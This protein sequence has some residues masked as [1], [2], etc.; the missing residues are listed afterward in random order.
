MGFEQTVFGFIAWP[1]GSERKVELRDLRL[2]PAD[3]RAAF[4]FFDRRIKAGGTFEDVV[5]DRDGGPATHF[6]FVRVGQTAAIL[7]LMD[8]VRKY[9]HSFTALLPRVDPAEDAQAVD[10]IRTRHGGLL[11]ISPEKFDAMVAA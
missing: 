8:K 10:I 4:E 6:R 7:V 3:E 5:R 11:K 9:L 2:S 1:E